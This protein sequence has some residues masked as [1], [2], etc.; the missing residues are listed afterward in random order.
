VTGRRGWSGDGGVCLQC[1]RRTRL[2]TFGSA[3]RPPAAQSTVGG[4]VAGS[5]M[6]PVTSFIRAGRGP[7]PGSVIVIGSR[8]VD[9]AHQRPELTA[10]LG[11]FCSPGLVRWTVGASR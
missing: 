3:V 11:T 7:R 8:R 6:R 10:R 4:I 5:G 9:A 2:A 1:V